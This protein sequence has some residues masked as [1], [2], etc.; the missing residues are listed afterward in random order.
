MTRRQRQR[1]ERT[2]L[3]LLAAA[4]SLFEQQGYASTTVADITKAAGRAHGTLY[5]YFD[6][7]RDLFTALLA[8]MGESITSHARDLWADEPTIDAIWLGVREFFH[9]TEENRYLWRLL[10]EMASVDEAAAKL[11]ADLRT[12]FVERIQRGI[13]LVADC[14]ADGLDPTL[15]AELLTAMVFNF[16]R[17]DQQPTSVDVLAMHVAVVWARGIGLPERDIDALRTRVVAA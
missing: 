1:T 7:K 16:A 17:T 8:G 2:R 4:R 12:G 14:S 6:D 5:L 13:E 15:L 3:A 9:V 11:R 10:E